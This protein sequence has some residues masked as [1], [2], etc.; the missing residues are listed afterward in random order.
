MLKRKDVYHFKIK[1]FSG[2]KQRDITE[3]TEVLGEISTN[4]YLLLIFII[5]TPFKVG[6]C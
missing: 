5:L 1:F 2:Y 4:T 3:F 6:E